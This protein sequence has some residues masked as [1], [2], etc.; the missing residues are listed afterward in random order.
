MTHARTGN[1]ALDAEG[2][3]TSRAARWIL[4]LAC[5]VALVRFVRLSYWSLWLD[6]T[7]TW[8]DLFVGLEDGE[9]HNPAGYRL[10]AW[11]V[12]LAGGVPDEFALR[13]LPAVAGVACVPMTFLAFRGMAG[14]KRA[15]CAALL[16]AASSWHVY[17]SQNARFYT[18]AQFC[19][20]VGAWL[21]FKA[22]ERGSTWRALLGLAAVASGAA[23]H[24]SV[25]F[26]LPA[27]VLAPFVV[28][29]CGGAVDA[30]ERRVARHVLVASVLAVIVGARWVYQAGRTYWIQKAHA[31][32]FDEIASSIAHYLK[33]T[34]FFVTPLLLA[35]ATV[36]LVFAWRRRDRAELFTAF[37]VLFCLSSALAAAVF[38]KVSAQ[39]VFFLLPWIALLAVTPLERGPDG[40]QGPRRG[41]EA[42]YVTVL[43][44]PALVGVALYLTVRQG[45]RPQW[46]EAYEFVWNTRREGDLVLGMHASVGEYY[47][48]PRATDLRQPMQV[49]WLDYF[50]TFDPKT[51]SKYPRRTWFVVNPEEFFD[52]RTEEA[53]AFQRLLREECRLV[54]VYPLY[55]ESRDLSVWVYLRE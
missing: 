49:A 29:L 15:A 36:G 20:L 30:R 16:V 50:H 24:P 55:V 27:L 42:A 23:F 31:A 38:V 4:L 48:S 14:G 9:I 6:E 45:E 2:A 26:L 13:I 43:C 8:T 51:W 18:L 33:T 35:G 5:A 41:L 1:E 11:A 47:L 40:A 37:V 34:G 22:F 53:T 3:S 28:S 12:K 44:L 17:W 19:V 46:R 32:S 10:I 25:V 21:A 7:L 54:K 52:W 39:Y